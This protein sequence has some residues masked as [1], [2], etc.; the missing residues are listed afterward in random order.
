MSERITIRDLEGVCRR[1][2]RTVNGTDYQEPWTKDEDGHNRASIGVYYLDGAYGGYALYR[3]ATE[4]G[5]VSDVLGLGHLSK[6]EL[7]HSMHAFLRGIEAIDA[8]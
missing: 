2:N 7:Y 4:S 3:M 5:G 6:R 1:I 8:V